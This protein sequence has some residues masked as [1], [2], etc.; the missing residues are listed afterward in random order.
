M[1]LSELVE[2]SC[3]VVKEIRCSKKEKQ[4]LEIIGVTIGVKVFLVRRALFLD[5]IE[6]KVRGCYLAIRKNLADN[7]VVENE[8]NS[9]FN[10]QS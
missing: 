2:G 6:I 4:K 3:A 5:P 8:K 10:W 1:K 9:S 7:I